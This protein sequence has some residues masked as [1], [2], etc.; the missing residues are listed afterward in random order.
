MSPTFD[1]DL[2]NTTPTRS[3][4]ATLGLA[5]SLISAAPARPPASL[6]RRL[7]R[8]REHADL[9]QLSW[10]DAGRPVETADLR[11]VDVVLDRR[12]GALRGRLEAC[13]QLGDDDHAPRAEV[14][15]GTLF[16]TGLDFLMLPYAEEWAQS[17]R[18]LV[19]IATDEL[20]DEIEALCGELYL[21]LLR[22]AHATY[23]EALGIT[24]RKGSPAEAARVI[25]PLKQ[26]KDAIASYVRGVI[27]T[28]NED[29]PES[30]A[31][32]QRQL[33]PILRA[34][35]TTTSGEVAAE[36]PTEPAESFDVPLP[37]LPAM[38]SAPSA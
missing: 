31:A 6:S 34:R 30:V 5:R 32:A 11:K 18:R 16:P 13:V 3:A 28:M 9:L 37:E 19:L 10:I 7:T 27:G 23:G 2:Y 8:L 36:E 26:L 24:K 12:W 20:E 1:P 21:P 35:R 15:L 25:E 33:E 38:I 17:E 4:A 22:Q 14:L 29:D